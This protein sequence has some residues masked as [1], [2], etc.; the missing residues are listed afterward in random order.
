MSEKFELRPV[1]ES[2]YQF[3]L[4]VNEVNV[5][6]LSPMDMTKLHKFVEMADVFTVALVNGERAAFQIALTEDASSYDS[7]N[8][9]W[10]KKK[11]EHFLYLDRIVIDEPFRRM[12]LGRA[13]YQ[14][15]FNYAKQNNIP[16]VTAEVDTIP[17]NGSSLKFHEEMGFHEVGTQVVRGGKIQVS[18]QAADMK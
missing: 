4:H 13:M 2:D 3:I 17:Y 1:N 9:Q 7:E 16:V 5:E 11:Y 15:L 6:V 8:Y 18:L 10:F 14:D 12:G